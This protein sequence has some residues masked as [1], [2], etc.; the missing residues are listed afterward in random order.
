MGRRGRLVKDGRGGYLTTWRLLCTAR[1]GWESTRRTARRRPQIYTW[2]IGCEGS[3]RRRRQPQAIKA[4]LLQVHLPPPFS[5]RPLFSFAACITTL[6]PAHKQGHCTSPTTSKRRYN[7]QRPLAL[8]RNSRRRHISDYAVSLTSAPFGPAFSQRVPPELTN[9]AM[10]NS[11]RDR[12]Q[13]LPLILASL[14]GLHPPS[15]AQAPEF[16]SSSAPPL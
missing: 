6:L 14:L 11:I 1:R 13:M 9:H 2:A 4:L 7:A 12:R 10:S 3:G 15:H 8:P 16:A 5:H